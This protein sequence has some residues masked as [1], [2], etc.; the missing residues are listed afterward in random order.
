MITC[1]QRNVVSEGKES[2]RHKQG[3]LLYKK[4][5]V[6]YCFFVL[7]VIFG[8]S[9]SMGAFGTAYGY[10]QTCEGVAAGHYHTCVLTTGGNVDCY[11]Y[12]IYGQSDDYS[13]GDAAGVTA[14]RLHTCVLTAGYNVDCYGDNAYGQSDDYTGGDAV[15]VATGYSH[16]C[17]LTAGGYVDCYGDNASGQSDDYSGGDA[18]GVTAGRYHTCVLTEGG[19]VDCYGD[20]TYGQSADYNSGDAVGVAAGYYH[21]CVLKANG[22]ADCYGYNIYGQS[23]DYNSG[24]AVGIATGYYHTCIL[25]TGANVVC[26]GHDSYGQSTDYTGGDAL[27]DLPQ[28]PDSD[29]DGIFDGSD[30]CPSV[31]N[32]DQT[33][34]DS[35]GFGD[36]CDACPD[37]PGNDVDRDGVC[38]DADNCPAASNSDQTDRD[39]DGFG[40]ACDDENLTARFNWYRGSG[41]FEINFEA[42]DL[43]ATIFEWNF[44]DG[45]T[46]SGRL[47]S[48]S[49]PSDD[50]L[51][52]ATLT[53]NEN[54]SRTLGIIVKKL[55][56][57]IGL[58]VSIWGPTPV[59]YLTLQEACDN[60]V[61]NDII[62]SKNTYFNGDLQ[63]NS[64]ITVFFWGGYDCGYSTIEGGTT[65][66][67]DMTI[68]DGTFAIQGG[69]LR[70]Q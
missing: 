58:P 9:L 37:D 64:A 46:G 41:C 34:R 53:V 2:W 38:G 28:D 6:I 20:N 70:V 33:D 42:E 21:T 59:Y 61:D 45:S 25:T 7:V 18:V 24:D 19:N 8:L 11:G 47:T 36:V 5:S 15:G 32:S 62:H 43:N 65:I 26:Y 55:D 39:S 30:N 35:D 67:G 23:A 66:N 4:I 1:I 57:Q 40:D 13:G 22:N 17:V 51:Y 14:G 48:H 68:S 50:L 69:V 16:T 10:G 52:T 56:H 3:H 29:G 31:Q 49:Y 60:A 27:C 44:G 54:K 12:N 63:F